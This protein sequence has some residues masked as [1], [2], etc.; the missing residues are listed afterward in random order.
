MISFRIQNDPT[1]SIGIT[2][3]GGII[4]IRNNVNLFNTHAEI[5]S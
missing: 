4:F 5:F 3:Y 1:N 2:R